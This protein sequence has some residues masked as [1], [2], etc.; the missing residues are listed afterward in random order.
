MVSIAHVG[1]G[2]W[3]RNIARSLSELGYLA[4]I[5]DSD[6]ETAKTAAARYGVAALSLEEALADR[7]IDAVSIASPAGR[8][9]A[10]A[11]M[12]LDAGKHVFVEKPM[13]LNVDEAEHLCK[14]AEERRLILMVGHL[15]H[16]HP[17][18][19]HLR[20]MVAG[21]CLGRLRHIHS[22]RLS[23][24]KFR[25]QENV[26]WSFAPH[27]ISMI[28]GLVD[29]EPHHVSAQGNVSFVPG[30][31]DLATVQMHFPSGVTGHVHASW[32]NPFKEQRLVVVGEHAMAVFEDSQPDWNDKLVIYRHRIDCDGPVP[33]QSR[34]E[35]E[36]IAIERAQPLKEEFR[37]FARCIE[38]GQAPR[39]DGW[40][41]LR[42][43]RVLDAAE[44]ALK[45]DLEM[46]RRA[47]K[48]GTA[49]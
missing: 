13:A 41:G 43:L 21:G 31:A 42:V 35:A 38:A 23:L 24:G 15:L 34:A 10:Q 16:Y 22:S 1:H 47:G 14:L 29:A 49:T 32:M 27:D 17:A 37:H 19:I 48:W 45:D 33:V 25:A 44:R 4:A 18:Y 2:Y 39:T 46:Q 40:E 3:G 8:H 26:L 9:V 5:I 36:R 6:A 7:S 12:V 20:A 28:L 11:C 30:I